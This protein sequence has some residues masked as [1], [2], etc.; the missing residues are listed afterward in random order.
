MQLRPDIQIKSMIKAMTE[1]IL[2]AVDPS[3]ELAIQQA[4]L[5]IGHMALLSQRLP[6][7]YRSDC[8]ELARLL[9]LFDSLASDA[10]IGGGDLSGPVEAARDVLARAKAE[11]EELVEAIRN[12]AAALDQPLQEAVSSKNENTRRTVLELVLNSSK[13]QLLRNRA[14]LIMQGWEPDPSAVPDITTLLSPV[15]VGT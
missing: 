12:L 7:Q 2:P 15:H 6:L 3:N 8:D 11:P 10:G 4:Q 9:Q 14:W 13:D 1:V 5:M